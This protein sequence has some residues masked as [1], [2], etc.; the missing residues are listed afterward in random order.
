MNKPKRGRPVGSSKQV[1]RVGVQTD[2]I[3]GAHDTNRPPRVAMGATLNLEFGHIPKDPGYHYRVVADRDGR[4][5]Q[6]Q[7]AWY[8]FVKDA[9][10]SNVVCHKGLHNQYLMRIERKYWDEDQRLKQTQLVGKLQQEQKLA[11]GE[12]VPDGRSHVLEKDDYDPLA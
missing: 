10:G 6:A 4:L 9:S 12:Y 2:R 8:E 1:E 11:T 3:A 7:G 5:E